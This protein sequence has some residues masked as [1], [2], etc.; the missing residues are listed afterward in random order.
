MDGGQGLT[1]RDDWPEPYR[2]I[3]NRGR[4]LLMQGTRQ[5]GDYQATAHMQ[6][7][8]CRAG[9]LAVRVQGM[10]RYYAL[11]LDQ[12]KARIIRTFE[13]QDTVLAQSE[14]GWQ[15]GQAYTLHLQVQG[16]RLVAAIDGETVLEAEDPLH[17]FTTGGIGLVAEAGRIGCDHVAVQPSSKP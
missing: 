4:G 5:W 7:H 15:W 11:L 16:N 3:Q 8:M 6:P 10:G 12:E 9:G 1:N 13:G 14:G 17:L 2:L